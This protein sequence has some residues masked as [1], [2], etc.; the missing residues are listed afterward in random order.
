MHEQVLQTKTT[1]QRD[2]HSGGGGN[3]ARGAT[4]GTC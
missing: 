4:D 1:T 3:G 2:A